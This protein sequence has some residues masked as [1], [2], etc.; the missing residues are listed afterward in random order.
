MRRARPP[1]PRPGC[2][3]RVVQ[4]AWPA[5][6]STLLPGVDLPPLR[7]ETGVPLEDRLL[8]VAAA[9]TTAAS[10][11]QRAWSLLG[12]WLEQQAH[13][14]GE[15]V[16]FR[17]LGDQLRAALWSDP[18]VAS[19]L[20]LVGQFPGRCDPSPGLEA[21]ER[22]IQRTGLNL[23]QLFRGALNVLGDGMA[24]VRALPERPQNQEIEGAAQKV[25]ARRRLRCHDVEILHIIV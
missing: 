10:E 1:S 5:R 19:A 4:P 22:R 13:G 21:I 7:G 17:L 14:S 6:P 8:C 20:A 12:H 24:V 15:G 23:Q 16:P 11:I 2:Q 3:D 25:D 18:I 9:A